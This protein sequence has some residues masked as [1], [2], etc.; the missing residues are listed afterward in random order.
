MQGSKANT[1]GGIRLLQTPVM[2]KLTLMEL[3]EDYR[4]KQAES[5][6][7][8]NN[9]FRFVRI[10]TSYYLHRQFGSPSNAPLCTDDDH[11]KLSNLT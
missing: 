11:I 9:H 2:P 8:P 3:I 1:N 5:A 6:L 4:A 10:H 7:L